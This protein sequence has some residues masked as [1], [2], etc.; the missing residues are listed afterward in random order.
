MPP[1]DLLPYAG[2]HVAWSWDGSRVVAGAPDE[3]EL[4]RKAADAGHDPQRVVYAFVDDPATSNL[5]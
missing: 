4:R 3:A 5:S 2:Q 1:E